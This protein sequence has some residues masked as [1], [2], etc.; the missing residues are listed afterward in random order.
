VTH[1]NASAN[2]LRAYYDKLVAL[3]KAL[4]GGD[5]PEEILAIGKD[6]AGDPRHLTEADE[7]FLRRADQA[8]RGAQ[9]GHGNLLGTQ[10]PE[11]L[12]GLDAELLGAPQFRKT[13]GIPY[14]THPID[15]TFELLQA[16]IADQIILLAEPMHDLPE[17]LPGQ[18]DKRLGITVPRADSQALL[19][20]WIHANMPDVARKL[21][22]TLEWLTKNRKADLTETDYYQDL[23]EEG[24]YDLLLA[25]M[26][27]RIVNLPSIFDVR[28][29]AD[30]ATKPLSTD[31]QGTEPARTNYRFAREQVAATLRYFI[32]LL[33]MKP[34]RPSIPADK[35]R[36]KLVRLLVN[37][38]LDKRL[39]QDGGL[40]MIYEATDK[41]RT[42]VNTA[43]AANL[44]RFISWLEDPQNKTA[45][46]DD[47]APGRMDEFIRRLK[48]HRIQ[49]ELGAS[50]S[51]IEKEMERGA[52][53][54]RTS[55]EMETLNLL[56]A[57][58]VLS[59]SIRLFNPLSGANLFPG[60]Y[61]KEMWT[62]D[63][64]LTEHTS[65]V[66]FQKLVNMIKR[67][68][69]PD[70]DERIPPMSR[71]APLHHD[72]FDLLAHPDVL[73]K[74]TQAM[75]PGDVVY[76]RHFIETLVAYEATPQE[77]RHLVKLL[78]EGMPAGARLVISEFAPFHWGPLDP[79]FPQ[80]LAESLIASGLFTDEKTRLFGNQSPRLDRM[81]QNPFLASPRSSLPE[82][83]FSVATL[84]SDR[85]GLQYRPGG[86]LD[87]LTKQP[88]ASQRNQQRLLGKS[89]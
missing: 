52:D 47:L 88:H 9:L 20:Q 18:R 89:A 78:A 32:P 85:V 58:G 45:L 53:M 7:R 38:V 84:T 33:M 11:E 59:R 12:V 72:S 13:N 23:Q 74:W 26:C 76:L 25:K 50:F 37:S 62:L 39:E 63:E 30:K 40:A 64:Q 48:Q 14:L 22:R 49:L 17:D 44:G 29:A 5:T 81:N 56:T 69:L 15:A 70:L 2:A 67:D 16:G 68:R 28:L 4:T 57:S 51:R 55:V 61:V 3:R 75:S 34:D 42:K 24:W 31:P 19:K 66:Y 82:D 73:T 46:P 36:A 43:Q 77:I 8:L 6:L 41:D 1:K 27:D 87:I 35:V 65:R 80:G 86:R 83:L 54:N 71:L 79:I 21:I 10:R 60:L